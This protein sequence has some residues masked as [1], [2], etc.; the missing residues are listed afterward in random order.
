MPDARDPWLA[1]Q[2]HRGR[3][4][5]RD[6]RRLLSLLVRALRTAVL[7]PAPGPGLALLVGPD[8]IRMGTTAVYLVRVCNPTSHPARLRLVADG[9]SDAPGAATFHFE[10]VID[11]PPDATASYRLST[12]WDGRA[13][14]GPA[15]D[16]GSD[17]I[18]EADS[19]APEHAAHGDVHLRLVDRG[20]TVDHLRVR[21]VIGA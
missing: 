14:L 13:A 2:R 20:M 10:R 11:V 1:R 9:T 18:D 15:P 19:G 7:E 3:I 16:V 5:V 17:P 12:S 4:A 8:A 6:G 21:T